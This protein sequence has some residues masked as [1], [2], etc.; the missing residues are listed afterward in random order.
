MGFGRSNTKGVYIIII[1]KNKIYNM[2]SL[3]YILNKKKVNKII[4]IY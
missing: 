2:I 4:L 1:Y 3:K